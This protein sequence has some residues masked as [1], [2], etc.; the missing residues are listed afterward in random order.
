MAPGNQLLSS[1]LAQMAARGVTHISLDATARQV[2]KL[3]QK[4][5]PQAAQT[6]PPQPRS[7]APQPEKAAPM[8]VAAVASP[9][10]PPSFS[11]REELDRLAMQAEHCER[12]RQLG[13]LR[14]VMVF[15]TGS[16]DAEIMFIGEAP[17]AEEEKQ[18]EPFVGPAGQLLTRIIQ[19]MGLRRSD[20]YISNI[21]KFRPKIDD[22]QN[23]G[24]KNR[25]P[26]VGEMLACQPFIMGEI[27]VIK[28][29]I[30]I[31]LGATAATGLGVEGTVGKLRANVHDWRGIPLIVTY[32]PSYLLRRE[33]EDGGGVTEKRLVWEDMMLAMQ[34][35]GLPISA[36]QRAYFSKAR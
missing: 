21:C 29:R 34:T 16:P 26:T 22:G 9:P 13:T 12:A 14:D 23:Q 24:S 27:S 5:S 4:R 7:P 32:H 3:G 36:K 8:P 15:A 25:V 17:G 31:C 18:R 2:L 19:A 20:V 33:A 28:P 35:I 1:Y 30:L 11:K 10:M 6:R